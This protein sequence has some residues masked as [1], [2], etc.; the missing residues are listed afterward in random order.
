MSSLSETEA[1]TTILDKSTTEKKVGHKKGIV[2]R[3]SG[4]VDMIL[5]SST[6]KKYENYGVL[7]LI[8]LFIYIKSQRNFLR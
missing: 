8:V 5:L 4:D 3:Y 1:K 2:I 7:V 6:V